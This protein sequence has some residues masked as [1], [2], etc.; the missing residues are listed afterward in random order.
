MKRAIAGLTMLLTSCMALSADCQVDFT[1][2]QVNTMQMSY[3]YAKG[4]DLGYTLAAIGWQESSAGV[5]MKGAWIKPKGTP[6]YYEWRAYGT[7]H[8]LL[9]TVMVREECDDYSTCGVFIRDRLLYDF[10]FAASHAMK[11]LKYWM[12]V[13]G[14][15][16]SKAVASYYAG[17]KYKLG[18]F[19]YKDIADK[20]KY[21]KRCKI[22]KTNELPEY[23]NLKDLLIER[24]VANSEREKSIKI[25]VTGMTETAALFVMTDDYGPVKKGMEIYIDADFHVH[26]PALGMIQ[27]G[28]YMSG[29]FVKMEYI[30]Y[31][32][33]IPQLQ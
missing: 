1:P 14:G 8:N 25:I 26:I 31:R 29:A 2:E 3:D 4:V 17:W 23:D 16:W 28:L 15:D 33:V 22:I 11:E 27:G 20:I 21:L 30:G 24:A 13:R 10:N 18:D 6:D 9:K 32:D 12:D 7:F 5:N 19:Y